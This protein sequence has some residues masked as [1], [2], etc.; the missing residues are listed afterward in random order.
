MIEWTFLL[1]GTVELVLPLS[2]AVY[3]WKKF[4]GSWIVFA[5]GSVVF[6]VSL[7]RIPLNLLVQNSLENHVSGTALLVAGALFLSVTVGLFEEGFRFLGY[8]YLFRPDKRDWQHGLMY[9][10]GH[11][12][13][14][15]VV[16]A[17]SSHLLMGLLLMSAPEL[18]PPATATEISTMHVYIP[19]IEALERAFILCVQIGLS[20]LVLQ[21]F[22][23][24][25]L[26]YLWYAVAFHTAVVFMAAVAEHVFLA[27]A[28]VG[29]CA[30]ISLYMIWNLRDTPS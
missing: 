1:A 10:T 6:L 16:L 20:I 14:E 21:C 19:F 26:Q 4:S 8:K 18:L 15:V 11:G 9:G 13:A 27:E 12:A 22:F 5:L 23:R 2:V 7:V 29:V 3:I 28:A 25:S 17:A 30:V 24:N